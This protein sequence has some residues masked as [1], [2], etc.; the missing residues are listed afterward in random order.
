LVTRLLAGTCSSGLIHHRYR[1]PY[2]VAVIT[3]SPSWCGRPSYGPRTGR[4]YCFS[5]IGFYTSG[6]VMVI[7]GNGRDEVAA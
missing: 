4:R 6:S 7:P 2:A 3:N 5:T 1:L